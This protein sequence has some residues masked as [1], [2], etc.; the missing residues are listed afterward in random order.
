MISKKVFYSLFIVTFLGI[1]IIPRTTFFNQYFEIFVLLLLA[2][3][4]VN[5]N[6]N[7]LLIFITSV[8]YVS[9]S[10]IYSII[11]NKAYILDFLLIY[12]FF[13]YVLPISFLA[14]K[15]IITES[16]FQKYFKFL[17]WAFLIKYIIIRCFFDWSR[18]VLFHE[19]NYELMF[20]SMLF[21]LKHILKGKSTVSD[22]VLLSMIY[23]FSESR[24]AL[25]I[26]LFI[27]FVVNKKIILKKLHLVL[28]ITIVL[29]LLVIQV[30]IERTD[31]DFDI[32]KIDRFKF[33]L[34]FFEETQGW[35]FMD[36]MLGAE[37]ITPLSEASC[38]KLRWWEKLF[39]YSGDGSCYSVILHSFL[40]R[41]IFDHGFLGLFFMMYTIYKAIKVSGFSSK[42]ALTL[43]V[44]VLINGLSVSSFN[45][46]YFIL[47]LVF[48][49]VLKKEKHF[50]SV[51][52]QLSLNP[53]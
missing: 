2:L 15:N 29:I 3:N 25:L 52:N 30:F 49:L 50:F 7:M 34:V 23:I 43:I 13:I 42:H 8:V 46:I 40:L 35:G 41:V 26:L 12:K 11:I 31:G 45:S 47:G 18:P 37:R 39:S 38:F 21:Y 17:I 1:V 22:Q 10:Y 27:L 19:N 53:K 51:T 44:I 33:M 9:A 16:F 6:K 48:F 24:S 5:I 36:Y 20:L 28:P 4:V 14:G 32:E